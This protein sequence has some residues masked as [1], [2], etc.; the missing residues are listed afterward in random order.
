MATYSD[1]DCDK[2]INGAWPN[3]QSCVSGKFFDVRVRG[4]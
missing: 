1:V 2:Q 3:E 4:T